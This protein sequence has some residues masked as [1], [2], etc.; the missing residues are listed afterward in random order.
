MHPA[1]PRTT[2]APA[3]PTTSKTAS[4]TTS[5]TISR[6]AQHRAPGRALPA[7]RTPKAVELG[8]SDSAAVLTNLLAGLKAVPEKPVV[9]VRTRLRDVLR[10]LW[11]RIDF[12][13]LAL[14]GKAGVG[15]SLAF[16]VVLLLWLASAGR[17][18]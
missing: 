7:R 11:R 13:G 18:G 8:D 17:L 3:G 1:L 2:P 5:P 6:G 10:A 4:R 15:A 9:D 14:V 12:A 16:T